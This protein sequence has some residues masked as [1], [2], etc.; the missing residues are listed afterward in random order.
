MLTKRWTELRAHP[1]QRRL[2]ESDARF[3]VVPAGRRGGKTEHAK[4]FALTGNLDKGF[5]G[6]LTCTQEQGWF[7]CAAPT[8]AQ[9]KRIYWRDLKRL[10]PSRYV[11]SI[12]EGELYIDF[13]NGAR[14]QCMGLDKP[15][16]IEGP[17][18]HGVVLDE[19]ANMKADLFDNHISPMLAETGGWAWFIGVPEAGGINDYQELFESACSSAEEFADWD[20]FTWESADILDPKEIARQRARMDPR[21]FD[22]EYRAKFVNVGGRTYYS[23]G[24]ENV[25]PCRHLYDPDQPLAFMFDFN[26]EPGTASVGQYLLRPEGWPTYVADKFFGVIGEVWRARDS[27]THL[28]CDDLLKGWGSHRGAVWLFGD[29]TGGNRGTAKTEGSDW[30]IIEK[31]FREVFGNRVFKKVPK[32]NPAE[33]A[34]V[35]AMNARIMTADGLR[36]FVVDGEECPHV[37]KDYKRVVCLPDGSIDKKK[38]KKLTHLSDG[39]GGWAAEMHPLRNK[40]FKI[41]RGY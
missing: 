33:R 29:A 6:A 7:V 37:V 18:L 1:E 14:L 25:A 13:V 3:R 19:Y 8:H 41:E 20:G 28:V 4:R 17:P 9:V 27:N 35:N 34:R 16:R 24:N 10:S 38:D 22:Q 39:I 36:R 23:F 30:D 21:T 11:K 26:V 2:V 5:E 12:S 31:R 40:G 32:G 15:E